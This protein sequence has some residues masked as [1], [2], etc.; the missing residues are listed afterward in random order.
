M[1]IL[2]HITS[3]NADYGEAQRY[4]MFQYDE[5]AMKPVLDESGRMI[6]REEYYLD[7]MNCDPF[8][9]DMECKELNAQ[10]RKNQTFDEIKSHHYI[11]SF[12][13]KDVTENGLTGER[14]QQLGIEYTRKNFPG[15]QALVCT[16]TDGNNE[17]GNIMKYNVSALN[18]LIN[19]DEDMEELIFYANI[20]PSC[21]RFIIRNSENT[22]EWD[23]ANDTLRRRYNTAL[24][25]CRDL[26]IDKIHHLG[27]F[28][29][30]FNGVS[31]FSGNTPK[32]VN[33][34]CYPNAEYYV[35]G[36]AYHEST[37]NLALMFSKASHEYIEIIN[38]R[39]GK[40]E[41]IYSTLLAHETLKSVQFHP[42]GKYL[43][44]TLATKCLE[45]NL[46]T[47][48]TF[49]VKET[50]TNELFIDGNYTNDSAPLIEIAI[51]EH[52]NYDVPRVEPHCD[53]FTVH[54]TS[55]NTTYTL[56]WRYY[57]P[58][59][60]PETAKNFLHY[61]YDIGA[62]ASYTKEEYQTYWCTQGF[63]LHDYPSAPVFRD[64][65]CI[66]FNG[67][68]SKTTVKKFENLQM[69]YCRHDF[70]LANQYRTEK[71][72]TVMPTVPII[73]QKSY[74]YRSIVIYNTGIIC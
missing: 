72:A 5:A 8:T 57:M 45:Y 59:L 6:P 24:Y 42:S 51:V 13:P 27:I 41:I 30:Q 25:D 15:H 32:L 60:T 49:T 33:A 56:D 66:K 54:R 68:R 53:H 22:Y 10:Y 55:E 28:V 67:K 7:G 70:P 1:A 12:D 50:E 74:K 18:K 20:V 64:I 73:S 29:H 17:S 47:S 48:E 35:S 34:F 36:C 61:S 21:N 62:G 44:I 11:L 2:K 71:T 19:D 16:H 31:I 40:R 23:T 4:L 65:Q 69:L 3:K 26:L 58:T 39:T 9:F 52:F 63:F 38:I 43:L 14:A 46:N 37:M